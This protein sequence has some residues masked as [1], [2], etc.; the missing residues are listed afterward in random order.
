MNRM[1]DRRSGSGASQREEKVSDSAPEKN[2]AISSENTPGNAQMVETL[3][4]QD[5]YE[6]ENAGGS[7]ETMEDRPE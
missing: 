5:K 4:S 2:P 6:E 3:K 1:K 7:A